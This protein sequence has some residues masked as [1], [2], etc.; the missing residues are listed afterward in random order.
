LLPP[1]LW[2]KDAALSTVAD[3]IAA[4]MTSLDVIASAQE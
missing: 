2:R 3:A 1:L 4:A